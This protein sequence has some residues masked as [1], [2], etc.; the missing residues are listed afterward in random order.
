MTENVILPALPETGP[1]APV[2]NVANLNFFYGSQQA[3]KNICL[4]IYPNEII[5]I[6]GPS[7]CGKSTLL[8]CFNRMN[9][10]I[11]GSR[12]EG[13][14]YFKGAEIEAMQKEEVRGSKIG[15]IF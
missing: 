2:I 7:G 5:A 3:L 9:D 12:G 14:I 11:A 6:I 10:E 1:V 13:K 15:D 8:R 4:D